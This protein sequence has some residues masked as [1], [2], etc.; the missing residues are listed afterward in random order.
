M[1]KDI[2]EGFQ[3]E[4]K[5][6]LNE[7]TLVVEFLENVSTEFP[8]KKL[9]EFAQKID[10]IMGTAKT[11]EMDSPDHPGLIRIGKLAELCKSLGYSAS[12]LKKPEIV[13]L[14]AAFWA[15]TL[16]VVSEL[17]ESLEDER[18]TKTIS[19][20]FSLVLQKRLTWLSEKINELA[21]K[22]GG[23]GLAQLDI[24]SILKEFQ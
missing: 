15:D 12:Q 7:L 10:R 5:Q 21:K 6:I 20:R 18:K 23:T 22:S 9:A 13:P 2:V 14:F 3:T 8:G 1:D 16:D 4:A 24:D 11:L 19:E 17:I